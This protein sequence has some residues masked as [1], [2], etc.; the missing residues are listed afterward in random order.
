M[1]P[2]RLRHCATI[3]FALF[4]ALATPA[5]ALPASAGKVVLT[6]TGKIAAK[7]SANTATFDLAML[8]K[9]PQQTFTTKT[10]WSVQ[11]VKFT[12][13][14]LR[15]VLAQVKANAA[16]VNLVATAGNDYKASIPYGD[17]LAH[18]MIIAHR[19][20]DRAIPSRTHGPLFII[21]P[22]DSKPAL[23]NETYYNRS[24]WQVK[25]LRVE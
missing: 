1:M 15:D 25:A 9:L 4:H 21:Y 12:G 7:N 13:P 5:F 22:F 24:V 11:P 20:D 19:M 3:F 2:R 14:L 16:A 18:D 23:Q 17:A 10:P 8:E 6:I